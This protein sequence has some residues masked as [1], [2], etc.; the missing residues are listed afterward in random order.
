MHRDE[1]IHQADKQDR[2]ASAAGDRCVRTPWHD[3]YADLLG[4]LGLYAQR[5]RWT[6]CGLSVCVDAFAHLAACEVLLRAGPAQAQA[7]GAELCRRA[8]AGIGGEIRVDW[9]EGPQWVDTHLPVRTALG[10]TPAHAARLL[11]MLGAPALLAL[12]HR[13]PEQLG[14]L[15]PDMLLAEDNRPLRAAD[16]TPRGA[17]RMRVHVFEFTAG[18]RFAGITP[19]RSSRIIVRFH[20][21]TLERDAAFEQLSPRLIRG[22]PG[23][24]AG[25]V[26]G[27]NALG[28]GPALDHGLGYA[29]PVVKSWAD[30][31]IGVIH[32]EMAG[33]ETALC[34]DKTLDQFTGEVTSIGMSLS[35]FQA[36]DPDAPHLADGMRRLGER[37]GVDRVCVHADDWAMSATR[38]D[39]A[40]ER[41]A[42]MMGCLMASARA[43]NG[44]LVVPQ[45]L[46]AEA[47][48]E[49]PPAEGARAG[50]HIV[51]C[52]SPHVERPRTTLGLGDTFMAGCLLVLGQEAMSPAIARETLGAVT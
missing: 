38:R 42:L 30:A 25:I 37:L 7:L 22:H 40:Q 8:A 52:P 21:L 18:E 43:A 31:G 6:V 23:L 3:A 39:P 29:R 16:V 33:Y 32:L 14:I 2:A 9:P 46:P 47:H 45:A 49:A 27:F 12:E 51:S 50:W 10:G 19:P 17:D 28:R 35:E 11:T 4:R 20:D 41:E 26:S 34:R 24:G 44:A 36:I 5:A 13:G 15:D 1:P 48:F